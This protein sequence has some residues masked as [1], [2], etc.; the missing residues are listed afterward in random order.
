MPPD[1]VGD[2]FM[3]LYGL[4]DVLVEDVVADVDEDLADDVGEDLADDV[5]ADVVVVVADVLVEDVVADVGEDLADGVV[6]DADAEVATASPEQC[7]DVSVID[8]DGYV[9]CALPPFGERGVIGRLTYFPKGVALEQTDIGMRCYL[10]A[11]CSVTRR[12]TQ[13]IGGAHEVMVV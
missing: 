1:V 6:A 10:H 9:S 13:N 8:P 4:A 11:N 2:V 3:E 12:G 7:A 5:V